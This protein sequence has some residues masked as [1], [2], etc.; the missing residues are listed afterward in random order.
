MLELEIAQLDMRY[1]SLRVRS[2]EREKRLVASISAVGQLVPIVVVSSHAAGGASIVIDGYKRVRAL[3]RLRHDLVCAT[4]WDLPEPE[5]LLLGRSLRQGGAETALEQGW[6]L[7]E[8]GRRFEFTLEDLARR[9]DKT[10]SWVSRRLGLVRELPDAVQERIRRGEIVPHAAAKF[11]I[12]LARANRD[13]CERLARAISRASLSS[14]EVGELYRAWRDGTCDARERLVSEPLLYLRARRAA[15]ES[16]TDGLGPREGLLRD[17]A[18]IAAASRRTRKRLREGLAALLGP[19]DLE[20]VK[21]GLSVARAEIDRTL[22]ELEAQRG[23]GGDAATQPTN[24]DPRTGEEGT[25]PSEDRQDGAG[26][27]RH[28]APGDRLWNA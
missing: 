23:G 27:A 12:P 3:A 20:G 5:A 13:Q 9:F 8:L 16:A 28:G 6:L 4:H 2:P 15:A 22:Q 7:D 25:I 18:I 24:R 10:E 21:S 11:L 1:E 19:A 17:V 26:L 14:R